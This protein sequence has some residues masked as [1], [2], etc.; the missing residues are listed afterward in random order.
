LVDA[1]NYTDEFGNYDAA[2]AANAAAGNK[3]TSFNDTFAANRLAFGPNQT[4]EWTNPATGVTGTYTTGTAE[5][6]QAAANAKINA[7]NTANLS[8][9]TDASQTVAAQNDATARALAAKNTA[10][11]TSA[12]NVL[13]ASANDYWSGSAETDALG[14]TI[15]ALQTPNLTVQQSDAETKR[16]LAQNAAL[17]KGNE[18]QSSAETNRLIAQ[19]TALDLARAQQ[20]AAAATTAI[21]SVLGKD[22]TATAIL[23]QGLSNLNQAVGQTIEF[24]GGTGSALGI[25]GPVNALTNALHALVRH[26][27]LSQLTKPLATLQTLL[28]TRKALTKSL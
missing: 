2:V 16:L 26:C 21:E 22:T 24:V 25:T 4:F 17:V 8:T 11:L 10:A 13:N 12:N 15:G 9:V 14:N 19:N 7:L 20:N 3:A 18:T 27:S 5:E 28:A 6:A 23:Q 1:G